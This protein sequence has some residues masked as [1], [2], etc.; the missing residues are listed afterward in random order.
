MR[1]LAVDVWILPGKGSAFSV[2]F[3]GKA[4]E[5]SKA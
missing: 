5:F 4:T 1:E 3:A 2:L